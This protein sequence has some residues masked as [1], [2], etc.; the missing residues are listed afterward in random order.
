[1]LTGSDG[2][3]W[4]RIATLVAV[5]V[6]VSVAFWVSRHPRQPRNPV[7]TDRSEPIQSALTPEERARVDQAIAAGRISVPDPVVTLSQSARNVPATRTPGPLFSL[8]SP[9]GTAVRS[10]RPQFT[11]SEAGADAY[12]VAIVDAGSG[13]EIARSAR[14]GGTSWTPGEDLARGGTYRW[15][16]TAHRGARNETEPRPPRPDARVIVLDQ[17]AAERID[18][19]ASRLAGEPLALGILLA[20]AGVI[21]EARV[22]LTRAVKIPA[23]ASAARRLLESLDR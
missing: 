12:T 15:E 23:T 18:G 21:S 5:V 2:K 10:S 9:V 20:E 6:M 14:I 17:G 4:R 13:R 11:W 22:D 7:V 1:M 19:M 8:I 3:R 16:V